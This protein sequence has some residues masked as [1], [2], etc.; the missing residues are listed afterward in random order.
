MTE[1]E[2]NNNKLM[3]E[4]DDIKIESSS[5]I[6]NIADELSSVNSELIKI[7]RQLED[8]SES[9]RER[10]EGLTIGHFSIG[11]FCVCLAVIFF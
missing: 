5:N 1:E 11:I 3:G 8:L 7:N 6:E 9:L 10:P 4:I 2:F